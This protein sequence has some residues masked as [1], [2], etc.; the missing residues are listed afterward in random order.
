[1]IVVFCGPPDS[2]KTTLSKLFHNWMKQNTRFKKIHYIDADKLKYVFDK[3]GQPT[4]DNALHSKA[5]DIAVYEHSINE[6]IL[7][8]M[9]FNHKSMRMPL[10]GPDTMW[11]FLNPNGRDIGVKLPEGYWDDIEYSHEINTECEAEKSLQEVCRIWD[12]KMAGR[13]Y[14]K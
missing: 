2:G 10:V 11:L 4:D 9:P 12:G 7:V 5:A 14:L 13:P 3:A 6:I 8:A 1:M